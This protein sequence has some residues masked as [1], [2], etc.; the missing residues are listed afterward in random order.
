MGE[1]LAA[2][3][4]R[5]ELIKSAAAEAGRRDADALRFVCR[6]VTRVRPGRHGGP[7]ATDGHL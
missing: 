5:T 3:A 4:G 7:T 2:V 6:G 1:D